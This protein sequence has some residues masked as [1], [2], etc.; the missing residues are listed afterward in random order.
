[1]NP[2][3]EAARQTPVINEVDLA[4]VGGSCTGVFAAVRASRLGLRVAIIEK[5]NCFGGMAT[6]ANV[7]VWHSLRDTLGQRQIIGGL[8]QEVLDRLAR[9]D[10]VLTSPN[11]SSAYRLNTEEL[12]VELD[13][14]VLSHGIVPYL[15]TFFA[16]SVLE[17]DRLDAVII[18]NKN[19]R[20]AL[21]ARQFIDATGDADLA[22]GLGLP[23]FEPETL[24]PPTLCAKIQGLGSLGGFKWQHALRRHGPEFGL[25][26]DWG[27][28]GPIPGQA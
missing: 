1:M 27:W 11:P 26:A 7:N 25:G 21:R 28:G 16:G 22:R 9:R 18:E 20:S 19:G 14:L 13:D 10:A 15:H 4:V 2:I 8:T 23:S 17:G 5:Q 3:K 12:K 6:S 24:Q